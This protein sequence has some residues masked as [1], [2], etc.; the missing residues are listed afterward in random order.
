M[1]KILGVITL[2]LGLLW[3]TGAF[4]VEGL[5]QSLRCYGTGAVCVLT[6]SW[7]AASNGTFTSRAITAS[8]VTTLENHFMY[9]IETD[10]GTAPT[11]AYDIVL[12][13]ARG[14]DI[15]GGAGMNKSATVTERVF[16]M[17]NGGNGFPPVAGETLTLGIS[18]NST[19]T[20]TGVI[21]LWFTK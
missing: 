18:G 21:K 6:L 2:C 8:Y 1:K 14:L 3:T 12:N 19:D 7:T 10:P 17:V 15:L 11:A 9:L 13:N 16:P 4:A 5:T 20:A